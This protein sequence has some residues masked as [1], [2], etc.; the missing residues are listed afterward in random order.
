MTSAVRLIDAPIFL[1]GFMG[2]GKSAVGLELASFLS[3][4]YIDL[5]REIERTSQKS[6]PDLISLKGEAEFRAIESNC[7]WEV[8]L[9]SDAVIATGGGI[10]LDAG[11]RLLMLRSGITVWLDAPLELCWSRI[12][13]DRAIRPLAPDRET[14]ETRFHDRLRYYQEAKLRIEVGE[15]MSPPTIA[16][17]IV[18][19]IAGLS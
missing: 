11:N 3:R 4:A 1:I 15:E 6:I 13:M 8:R 2:S 9:R 14:A 7:L 10:V 19:A 17:A 12:A 18:A 5:D 16:Q